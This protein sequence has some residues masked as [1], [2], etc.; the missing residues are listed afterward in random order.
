MTVDLEIWR[1]WTMTTTHD[2]DHEE[3]NYF[4]L[5]ACEWGPLSFGKAVGST[6]T[7]QAIV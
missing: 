3:T 4:I 5:C 7:N 2:D 6:Q 1:S